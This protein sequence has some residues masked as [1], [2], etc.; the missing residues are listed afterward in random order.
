MDTMTTPR[1]RLGA[2]TRKAVL[3]THIAAAGSWLGLDL[4]LGVLVVTALLGGDDASVAVALAAFA[5]WPLVAVG[6]LTLLSGIVLGWGT[7]YGLLRYWWVLLKLVAN[8]V[9]LTLVVLLLSPE[10][11]ALAAQARTALAGGTS[12]AIGSALLFPPLVSTTAVAAAMA[13]SVFKPW[14]RIRRRPAQSPA[15]TA[16]PGVSQLPPT[17]AT[18]SRA[19]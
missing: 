7:R 13:L 5:T 2:R 3:L 18:L 14:G 10:V 12:F 6:A 9:L 1:R 4:V 19:R 16:S 17:H 11:T 8:A 15:R